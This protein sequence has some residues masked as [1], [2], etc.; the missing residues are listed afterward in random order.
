MKIR[1]A[2]SGA[3]GAQP[4]PVRTAPP[5]EERFA[6]I[7]RLRPP[8]R[9][10]RTPRE[11]V[12]ARTW[13]LALAFPGGSRSEAPFPLRWARSPGG[14]SRSG[15]P[16]PSMSAPLRALTTVDSHLESH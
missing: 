10:L 5:A 2:H 12:R 6:P 16:A 14:G 9:P 8:E 11:G 3:A 15:F 7:L 13:A 4:V 1:T